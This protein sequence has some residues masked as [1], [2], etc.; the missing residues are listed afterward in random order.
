MLTQLAPWDAGGV[1]LPLRVDPADGGDSPGEKMVRLDVTGSGFCI[2]KSSFQP[3]SV[4]TDG[5]VF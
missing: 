4:P 3:I 1:L 2:V 5:D